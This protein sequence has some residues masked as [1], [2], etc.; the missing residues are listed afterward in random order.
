MKLIKKYKEE[1]EQKTFIYCPRC[2]TE[3]ISNEN[4]IE[5]KEGIVEYECSKCGCISFWD[6]SFLPTYLITQILNLK[7]NNMETIIEL[8]SED[9]R[10][11]IAKKCGVDVDDVILKVE[12]RCAGYCK[13]EHKEN[14][15]SA[16]VIQK[17]EK[18]SEWF[19]QK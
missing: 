18:Q 11:I 2:N 12:P 1:K 13:G 19:A 10:K 3:M 14:I 7:G 8:D 15:V 9:I 4:F 17:W 6:F 5:D 16:R